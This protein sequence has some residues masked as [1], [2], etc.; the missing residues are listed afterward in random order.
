MIRIVQQP[1]GGWW[2]GALG[3]STGWFP[4]NHVVP[5]DTPAPLLESRS[6]ASLEGA[7]KSTPLEKCV[8]GVFLVRF[9]LHSS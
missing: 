8:R 9:G 2:Q 1:E 5:K 3:S 7:N 4:S 6:S